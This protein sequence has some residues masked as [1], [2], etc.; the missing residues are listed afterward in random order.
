V[1]LV[2]EGAP[3][4]LDQFV[5]AVAGEMDRH[6]RHRQ[7]SVLRATGEFTNFEVRH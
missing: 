1:L 6:V 3:D 4:T 5:D 2:V 7:A